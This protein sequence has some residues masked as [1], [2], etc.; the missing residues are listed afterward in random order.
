MN[1]EIENLIIS[2]AKAISALTTAL[3]QEKEERKKADL[4]WEKDRHK[5]YQYLGRIASAQS[6]FYE[7]QS[8]YYEQITILSEKQ[9]KL[10]EKQIK[11]EEK[12]LEVQG[13]I[14]ELLQ[15]LSSQ[16]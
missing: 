15:Y 7:V 9:T 4:Q 12:Q 5:L 10:E 1:S 14:A 6:H 8:D 2:N 3:N 16:E 11:L 13:Q